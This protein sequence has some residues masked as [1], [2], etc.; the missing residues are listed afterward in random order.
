MST[1]KC[2]CAGRGTVHASY[3]AMT[4]CYCNRAV[5]FNVIISTNVGSDYC[6]SGIVWN[7]VYKNN[8][9]HNMIQNCFL[10]LIL[11]AFVLPN[12]HV[13]VDPVHVTHFPSNGYGAA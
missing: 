8:K 7:V 6:S 13:F 1:G 3:Q 5:P 11:P 12:I 9:I 2:H 10:C 4:V